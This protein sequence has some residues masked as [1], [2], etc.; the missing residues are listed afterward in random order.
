MTNSNNQSSVNYMYYFAGEINADTRAYKRQNN[1]NQ[2]FSQLNDRADIL[3]WVEYL[4]TH[5]ECKSKLFIDSGAFSV[6]SVGKTVDV[7][8]YID[9]INSI[10]DYVEVF[11]QVDVIPKF[12]SSLDEVDKCCKESWDNYLYMVSRVKSPEKLI[13]VFHQGDD[14]K[15]LINMLNYKYP[16]TGE[17][18]KY[19]GVSC[20]KALGKYYWGPFFDMCMSTIQAHPNNKVC[21]HAFGTTSIDMLL[22]YPFTSSDSTTWLKQGIYG[23]LINDNGHPMGFRR[24]DKKGISTVYRE[25]IENIIKQYPEYFSEISSAEELVENSKLCQM[26]NLINIHKCLEKRFVNKSI[27]KISVKK[28]L[29]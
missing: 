9:F 17:Y 11:A 10:D 16:E 14:I 21:V 6:A 19:I 4:K 27:P 13:P 8:D 25:Y 26:F 23:T 28:S 29:W 12:G 3:D 2:L 20:N 15:W 1:L 5:P 7:D 24:N 22:E 18:I